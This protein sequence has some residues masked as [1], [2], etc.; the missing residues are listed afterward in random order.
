MKR[1]MC[2]TPIPSSWTI[3]RR[4]GKNVLLLPSLRWNTFVKI[5]CFFSVFVSHR[6]FRIASNQSCYVISYNWSLFS[7]LSRIS[8]II[9]RSF[10]HI[11]DLW[12][13]VIELSTRFRALKVL[14]ISIFPSW[15]NNICPS[16]FRKHASVHFS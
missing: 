10:F 15:E 2:K 5:G 14:Q 12:Y 11:K 16:Q 1:L 6:W 7:S 8:D 3:Q 13:I 4:V 9:F